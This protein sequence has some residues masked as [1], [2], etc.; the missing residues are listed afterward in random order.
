M[1]QAIWKVYN[2]Q[3]RRYETINPAQAQ[4]DQTVVKM[5]WSKNAERFVTIPGASLYKVNASGQM[6][7]V[8]E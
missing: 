1:K 7:L 3:T 8:T 5:F 4:P 6:E 2:K